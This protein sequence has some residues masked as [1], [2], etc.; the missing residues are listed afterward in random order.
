LK[1]S[2]QL[3]RWLRVVAW[4]ALA[5]LFFN[6][7][8]ILRPGMPNSSSDES[9]M[10]A[11][12]Q[13]E[14]QGLAFGRDIVFTVGPYSAVYTHA[15]HPGTVWIMVV[16]CLL[17]DLCYASCFIWLVRRARWSWPLIMAALLVT[18]LIR[19][20]AFFFSFLLLLALVLFRLHDE[21]QDNPAKPSTLL[22]LAVLFGCSGM[23]PFVKI[24]F[25]IA[26]LGVFALCLCFLAFHRRW[27]MALI[28]FLSLFVGMLVSWVAVGQKL[29][30]L[31]AFFSASVP[32]IS[33]YSQAM[34]QPGP[35]RDQLLFLLGA[36]GILLLIV[37]AR[38]FQR[39]QKYFLLLAYA[40]YIFVIFKEGFDRH[41]DSHVAIAQG[42]LAVGVLSLTLLQTP[43]RR[44]FNT[45]LCLAVFVIALLPMGF[46]WHNH[47]ESDSEVGGQA[48]Q[49]ENA[50]Q[51]PAPVTRMSTDLGARILRKLGLLSLPDTA[52][53]GPWNAEPWTWHRS[54]DEARQAIA[55]GSELDFSMPGSVDMYADEQPALLSRGYSW[56][57]RLVFQSYSAYMPSLIRRNEQHLRGSAAPDHIVFELDPI[58]DRLPALDDGLSWPAMLDNYRVAEVAND[59]VHLTRKPGPLRRESRFT[60]LGTASVR[61]GQEVALP[62]CD[63]PIFAQIDLNPNL[64]GRLVDTVYKLPLLS[65]TLLT[66]NGQRVSYRV[67]AGMMKT[68]FFVSPL[69]TDNEGFVRLFDASHPPLE[70]KVRSLRLDAS[71]PG[72]PDTYTITFRRY[73]Y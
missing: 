18:P 32:I 39:Q 34:S 40:F 21:A 64:Y 55:A 47:F 9:W 25:A 59:W 53:L 20:D 41:D 26:E 51:P 42:G 30:D 29:A 52:T 66:N 72:W 2:L 16:G 28:C 57:P 13:A 68:G 19:P 12:N 67:I 50:P 3:G 73:E 48:P 23:L 17:L 10:Y 49:W 22:W 15:Y 54:F 69:I 33:G 63:G 37:F 46:M 70:D 58:N 1:G 62:S 8:G 35:L 65:L 14:A 43:Q 27:T 44:H 5:V 38:H 61:L 11:V 31:P 60:P 24:S 36:L 4:C 7:F 71:G 6:S 45:A 56:D